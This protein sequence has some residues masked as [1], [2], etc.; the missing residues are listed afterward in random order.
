MATER[1]QAIGRITAHQRQAQDALM[2]EGKST[3]Q[4]EAIYTQYQKRFSGGGPGPIAVQAGDRD[5][6][7]PRNP[8]TQQKHQP[9]GQALAEPE[10]PGT[11]RPHTTG[12]LLTPIASEQPEQAHQEPPA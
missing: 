9:T 4:A 7:R 8:R 6:Q 12:S 10:P 5:Q 3:E 1:D 11:P 2:G